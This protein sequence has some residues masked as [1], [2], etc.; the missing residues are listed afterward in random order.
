MY[1][2]F[3]WRFTAW[4]DKHQECWFS[5]LYLRSIC[6][7]SANPSG[8]AVKGYGLRPI[9]CWD[10]GFEFRWGHGCLSLSSI[11]CVVRYR[12]PRR[13]DPSYRGDLPTVV[14][15]CVWSRNL[16]N[17]AALAR[18]GLWR[19]TEKIWRWRQQ[20]SP[21]LWY[22]KYVTSTRYSITEN[23]KLLYEI[24]WA[25]GII[26]MVRHSIV[27]TRSPKDRWNWI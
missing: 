12:F 26:N 1:L 14:C 4:W 10:C 11:V 2:Q 3:L 23:K 22:L 17:E 7:W 19:Q 16:K 5:V 13:A 6:W 24:F 9:A 18:V 27:G 8:S 25:C 21:L 15:H 20:N